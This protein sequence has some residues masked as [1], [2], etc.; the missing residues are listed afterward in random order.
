M[1]NLHI[2]IKLSLNF[3]LFPPFCLKNPN[4][5]VTL[6]PPPQNKPF[7]NAVMFNLTYNVKIYMTMSL[8]FEI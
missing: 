5:P 2:Q 4:P 8:K 6:P 7:S 1:E 3:N